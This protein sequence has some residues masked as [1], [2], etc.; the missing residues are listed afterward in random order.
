M[1]VV[2]VTPS[3]TLCADDVGTVRST[4]KSTVSWQWIASWKDFRLLCRSSVVSL[5]RRFASLLP[6]AAIHIGTGRKEE[7]SGMNGH[8]EG[9]YQFRGG[10]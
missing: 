3:R 5:D 8:G 10:N 1:A 4:S 6:L 2:N 9:A 7:K